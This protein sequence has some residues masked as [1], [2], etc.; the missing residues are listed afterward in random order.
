MELALVHLRANAEHLGAEAA[1]LEVLGVARLGNACIVASRFPDAE[2]VLNAALKGWQSVDYRE[3]WIE[4]EMTFHRSTL[5]LLQGHHLEAERLLDHAIS[6]CSDGKPARLLAQCLIQRSAIAGYMNRLKE[7]IRDLHAARAVLENQN[8]PRLML[9]VYGNL[10]TSHALANEPA[11]A[12]SHLVS[13]KALCHAL[14]DRFICQH[15]HWIEALICVGRGDLETASIELEKARSGFKSVDQP[16][17]AAMA[18]LELAMVRIEQGRFKEVVALAAEATPVLEHFRHST[19][20]AA[21]LVLLREGLVA[22]QITREVLEQARKAL[23]G[24]WRGSGDPEVRALELMMGAWV[25]SATGW[26]RAPGERLL[27]AEQA[28]LRFLES[29][30][31]PGHLAELRVHQGIAAARRGD[32]EGARGRFLDAAAHMP[33]R[34]VYGRF[35]VAYLLA[36]LG[37]ET[38]DEAISR[39]CNFR[40]VD[41]YGRRLG[42]RS[43]QPYVDVSAGAPWQLKVRQCPRGPHNADAA[44][45]TLTHGLMPH[46]PALDAALATYLTAL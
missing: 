35:F 17:Y 3:I 13:A 24:L 11:E 40:D 41:S 23:H 30:P 45:P 7:S 9:A 18:A 29:H 12:E 10:A 42:K 5:R 4:A 15:L 39:L 22:R 1:G 26:E 34:C 44:R 28:L 16:G 36:A 27:V 43:R 31:S 46:S 20:I 2:Q 32:Y 21:A 37:L 33:E 8:E 19:G 25:G 14:A 38:G 6:I